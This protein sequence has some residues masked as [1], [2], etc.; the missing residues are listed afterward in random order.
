[1]KDFQIRSYSKTELG[2]LYAPHTCKKNA[3]RVVSRWIE[4]CRPLQESLRA[5]GLSTHTR[6]LSPK[7]VQIIINYLGV[8]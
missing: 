4:Q 6:N 8:P 3:W 5:T 7:Q 2:Q 1:M